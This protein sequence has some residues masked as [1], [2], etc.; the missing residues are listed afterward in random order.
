MQ[1]LYLTKSLIDFSPPPS[2]F[3]SAPKVKTP[4]IKN[5]LAAQSASGLEPVSMYLETVM[6]LSTTLYFVIR[7]DA[8]NEYGENV[9]LLLQ[10]AI[11]VA[12]MWHYTKTS[13]AEV[14]AVLAAFAAFSAAAFALP[15]GEGGALFAANTDPS[16]GGLLPVVPCTAVL[17]ALPMP[18]ML[19][20]RLPQIY[21]NFRNGHTGIQSKVTMTLNTLGSTARVF[22]TLQ[23]PAFDA[24]ALATILASVALNFTLA[25]QCFAF[26]AATKEALKKEKAAQQKKKQ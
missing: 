26:S 21:T 4:I 15:P 14:V 25:A 6:Y 2:P 3:P 9:F 5:I 20:S 12:L 16:S 24:A 7:G 19:F 11:I 13:A 23:K 17:V 18:L 22:T 1:P 10:N 8:F